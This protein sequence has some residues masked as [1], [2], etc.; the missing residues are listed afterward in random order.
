MCGR[1]HV[2]SFSRK[3]IQFWDSD[4]PFIQFWDSDRPFVQFGESPNGGGPFFVVKIFRYIDI[5][6]I[7]FARGWG[8]LLLDRLHNFNIVADLFTLAASDRLLLYYFSSL[9]VV[10]VFA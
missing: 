10:T 3:F 1:N 2:L 7:Y 4:R 5:D 8:G 6:K 9:Q